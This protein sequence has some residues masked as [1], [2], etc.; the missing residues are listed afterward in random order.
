MLPI[1]SLMSVKYIVA[2]IFTTSPDVQETVL[3][4]S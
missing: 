2:N 1:Y 3:M 4:W